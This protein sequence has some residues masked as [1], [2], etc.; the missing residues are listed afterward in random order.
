VAIA[1]IP[2]D[3]IIP[4]KDAEGAS[5][6]ISNLP[7]KVQEAYQDVTA[8]S[9]KTVWIFLTAISSLAFLVS[10]CMKDLKLDYDVLQDDKPVLE[11]GA[12]TVD[13]ASPAPPN[14]GS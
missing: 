7:L 6:L 3:F 13:E 4:A 9:I 2:T 11:L 14:P 10:L 1:R 5:D 8:G 12:S